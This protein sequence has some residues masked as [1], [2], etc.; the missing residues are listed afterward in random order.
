[1]NAVW[2][3]RHEPTPAQLEE[4]EKKG[5]TLLNVEKG[6][7]LGSVELVSEEQADQVRRALISL[8]KEADAEAVFGVFPV[9]IATDLFTS[10]WDG[11]GHG[12][13]QAFSA[14]N[15]RR[16]VEGG[17][18]TFEHKKWCSLGYLA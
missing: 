12:K 7:E 6:R 11:L 1:M 15:V 3:S 10:G 8:C 5:F 9:P 16:S 14:W 4:I 17:R 2:F 13:I 18:A